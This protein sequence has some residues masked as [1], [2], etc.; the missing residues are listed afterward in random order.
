VNV[1]NAGFH[2]VAVTPKMELTP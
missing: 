2:T 1:V